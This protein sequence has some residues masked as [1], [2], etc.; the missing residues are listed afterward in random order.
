MHLTIEITMTDG[1]VITK[2]Y[3]PETTLS[4][5]LA[6]FNLVTNLTLAVSA[7]MYAIDD[8]S[9]QETVMSEWTRSELVAEE[10][11]SLQGQ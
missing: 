8:L 5:L 10:L 2:A 9:N 11:V 7:A 6:E 4:E 3:P 1:S